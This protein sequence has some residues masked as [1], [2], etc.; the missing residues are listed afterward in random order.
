[1]PHGGVYEWGV[2]VPQMVRRSSLTGL[3]NDEWR[4]KQQVIPP[5]QVAALTVAMG[6]ELT[7]S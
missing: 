6:A 3:T 5:S 7:E 2:G 1:M 4:G